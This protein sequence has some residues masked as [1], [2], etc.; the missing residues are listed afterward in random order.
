MKHLSELLP[1]TSTIAAP[2][3]QKA[4]TSAPGSTVTVGS[5]T[6]R[7]AQSRQEGVADM[8]AVSALANQLR[9]NS[10]WPTAPTVELRTHRAVLL[11]EAMTPATYED[12]SYL[13]ARFVNNFPP[14][15]ADQHAIVIG[16]IADAC[17][18]HGISVIALC[19]AL[20][21]LIEAATSASPFLPPSG[22]IISRAKRKTELFASCLESDLKHLGA[23][24]VA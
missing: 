2:S 12:A 22:E 8:G 6:T 24:R 19:V 17:Q 16:D 20:K 23:S 13:V 4:S 1:N 7:L 5:T 15:S 11:T 9:S 10:L 3:T 18:Q 21:E 14:R